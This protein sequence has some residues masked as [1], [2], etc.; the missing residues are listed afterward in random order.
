MQNLKNIKLSKYTSLKIGGQVENFYVV[1]NENELRQIL[2]NSEKNLKILGCGTN[3][4]INDS[5]LEF[6]VIK[7]D[8]EFK[9]IDDLRVGSAVLLNRFLQHLADKNLSGLEILSGI[10]GTIGGAI[11]GNAGSKYGCILDFVRSVKIMDFEGN[12]KVFDKKDLDYGYRKSGISK[13]SIILE[14]EFD[15]TKFKNIDSEK[16]KILMKE[17]LKE[18]VAGQPYDELSAGCVFKNCEGISTGKMIDELGLKGL[19]RGKVKVSEKHGNFFVVEKD[20]KF[21]DFIDL[22]EEIRDKIYNSK[23]IRLEVE[24]NIWE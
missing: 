14:I 4:L 17:I 13:D 5:Q 2:K 22:I 16:I 18:K 1:E 21:K 3:L 24:L 10:P 8:G 20:A 11:F 9:K 12:V 23:Q 6:D 19:S 15:S 7:L